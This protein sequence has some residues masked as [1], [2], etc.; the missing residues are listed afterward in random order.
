ME[1]NEDEEDEP[2]AEDRNVYQALAG[3]IAASEWSVQVSNA[4]ICEGKYTNYWSK[5]LAPSHRLL[6]KIH[7]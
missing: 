3:G 4:K 1:E 7:F 2:D 5:S 6:L